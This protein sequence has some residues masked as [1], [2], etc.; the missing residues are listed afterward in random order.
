MKKT[1]GSIFV[2]FLGFGILALL[3]IIV[4]VKTF[5]THNGSS[6][7][8]L[9]G[10]IF[11]VNMFVV[12]GYS[13]AIVRTEALLSEEDAADLAYYLGFSLTVASLALSFISD[14][15]MASNAEANSSLVKG[16]LAQFGSGL[17][18]TLIG[19]CAKIFIASK[20]A[21]LASN[22]EVLYQE[23]RMEIRG[24]ENALSAMASSLDTSIKSACLSI[25][26]SAESAA[27]SMETLSER[28]KVSS[29]SIAENLTVE[30]IAKP[31]AAFS[32]ELLKLQKP[33]NQFT[34]EMTSL[35]DSASSI[36]KGLN[37]LGTTISDVRKSTIEEI[38]NIDGL[39][40]TK[41]RLNETS[42][43]SIELFEVQNTAIAE[44][45]KQLVKLKNSSTK[46]SE[47]YEL[48]DA[49]SLK[50]IN[51]S[52]EL[53]EGLTTVNHS[54]LEVTQKLA[55]LIAFTN[56]FGSALRSSGE[57]V[58][59]LSVRSA[60]ANSNLTGTTNALSEVTVKLIGLPAS[61]DKT[62]SSLNALTS[63][64]TTTANST[65]PL[66]RSFNNVNAPLNETSVSAKS[67][68][69]AIEKLNQEVERLSRVV[70]KN[71]G[72]T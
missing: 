54:I 3:C 65:E 30:K 15:G 36:T 22:P 63:S 46:T 61:L 27:L 32:D 51:R 33:A 64:L 19:L 13:F 26:S 14:V 21:N 7:L 72:Q 59:V 50:L 1:A 42:K 35:V 6:T 57:S 60:A 18:A 49:A 34:T 58:E 37:D 17:L 48:V 10:S 56:D 16:S 55:E 45:S 44:S 29:D 68:H 8:V 23:F 66:V 71:T 38:K 39:I 47:S 9:A 12:L 69:L 24:F 31:I 40:E 70:T 5:A 25:S 11:V 2:R 52:E 62:L 43:I 41:K 4:G 53:S 20:Q 67:L 28:L